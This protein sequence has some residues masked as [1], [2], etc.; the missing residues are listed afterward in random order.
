[1]TWIPRVDNNFENKQTK[2]QPNWN[3][4]QLINKKNNNNLETGLHEKVRNRKG[5]Q[6]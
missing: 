5:H 3:N 4:K 6:R 1:M 2:K